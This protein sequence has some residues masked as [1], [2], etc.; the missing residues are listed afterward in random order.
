MC[1][2]RPPPRRGVTGEVPRRATVGASVVTDVAAK[3]LWLLLA[4]GQRLIGVVL[5]RSLV[6]TPASRS[7]A[8]RSERSF[9]SESSIKSS[10]PTAYW[11]FCKLLQQ[12]KPRF[13]RLLQSPLPDSNRSPPPYHRAARREAR[14]SAGTRGHESPAR[15]RKRPKTSDR[16]CRLVP[17]LVF[18]QCSLAHRCASG[19]SGS[20]I[21]TRELRQEH[22]WTSLSVPEASDD[23]GPT[24][25]RFDHAS[26]S[27][28]YCANAGAMA[29]TMV[30]VGGSPPPMS[31]RKG[32]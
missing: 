6:E 25:G 17:G 9:G 16:A 24:K 15:R 12:E 5:E 31:S 11:S 14:A 21:T 4:Y 8:R 7:N 13:A 20:S 32:G 26:Q 3:R 27:H 10:I 22:G 1:C 30:S 28:R 23:R 29:G 2:L 18:P 19:A